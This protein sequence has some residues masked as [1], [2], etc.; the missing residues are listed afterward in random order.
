MKKTFVFLV[1]AAVSLVACTREELNPEEQHPVVKT[2]LT[3]GTAQTK[4][5]LGDAQDG[6]RQLYWANGDMINVN[7]VNSAELAGLTANTATS[8]DFSFVGSLETPYKALYPASIYKNATTVTLPHNAGNQV[9]PLGGVSE[10]TPFSLSPLTSMLLIKIKQAASE[11]DTDNITLIEV[12]TESTRMSGEFTIDDNYTAL[13]PAA[14]PSGDDLKVQIT[15][16]W[17]LAAEATNF[18]IPVPAGEYSFTVKVM[19]S[20][21]HYMTKS[22]TSAKEFTAGSIKPL[23]EFAFE[24]DQE[25]G[26][27]IDSP[28]ALIAFA[29]AYNRGDYAELGRDLVATVTADLTFDATTSAAFNATGGIGAGGS[30]DPLFNGVFDGGNHSINGLAATVPLFARVGQYGTVKNVVMGSSSSHTHSDAISANTYVASIAGYCKGNITG[31]TNNAPVT[32]SSTTRSAGVIY[33]GGIVAR[34]NQSGTVSS[35]ENNGAVTCSTLVGSDNVYVGGIMG[36]VERPGANDTALIE[37]CSNY[38]AIKCGVT[39]KDDPAQ[40]YKLHMAGVVGWLYSTSSSAK[41]IIS[42]LSNYGDVTKTQNSAKANGTWVLLGGIVAGIHG[43]GLGDASGKVEIKDS[44]VANCSIQNG[45][46]N[47]NS[48]YDTATHT[49]GFVGLAKGGNKD[50]IVFNDNCEVRNVE[51]IC[52]RAFAGGFASCVEGTTITDCNV[53]S[54]S[55]KGSLAQLRRGGGLVGYSRGNVTLKDCIVTLTKDS[56]YSLY[57]ATDTNN[58]VFIGGIVGATANT[59]AIDGCKAYIRLMYVG[60]HK[61]ESGDSHG[62]ILG[63]GATSTTIKNCGL[64]GTFG[65]NSASITLT[66]SN[67]SDYICGAGSTADVKDSNFYWDGSD[68]PV[69]KTV[70]ITIQ[71]Y[72]TSNGWT[73]GTQYSTISKGD[74]TLTASQSGTSKNG[75]YFNDVKDWRFYQARGGGLTVSVPEGRSLIRAKFIY[76]TTNTGVLKEGSNQVLSGTTYALSGTS[77]FFTVGNTGTVTNGQVRITKIV[78]EYE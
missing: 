37:F 24:P 39:V 44:H 14:S 9:I 12:S 36:T 52:Y 16:N 59:N 2:V 43:A 73:S 42:G 34:Q 32:C 77:A 13:T 66:D 33:M 63:N 1:L 21:G 65:K 49:G 76:D 68:A 5:T 67:F 15:G 22:T 28:E 78:I 31:C 30:N 57:G 11:P 3:V 23:K 45:N 69:G 26:L 29:K 70:S 71:D 72:A 56:Q 61:A 18:F 62:W 75:F 53:L 38:G 58:D 47:N 27:E 48:G 20:K 51:V 7:G 60:T 54:S 64:G 50:D 40:A 55:V 74:L 25:G 6:Q 35:C 10:S 8:A 19:D 17:T 41:M 46:F 4:T